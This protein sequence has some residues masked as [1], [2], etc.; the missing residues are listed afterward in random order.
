MRLA[1]M[2]TETMGPFLFLLF[3][4]GRTFIQHPPHAGRL[5]GGCSSL[6]FPEEEKQVD[7]DQ[8][9]PHGWPLAE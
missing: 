9:D 6:H 3:F 5:L 8:G 2:E 7:R 1:S 4:K